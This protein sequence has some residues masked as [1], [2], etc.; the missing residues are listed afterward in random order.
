MY[1]VL[2]GFVLSPPPPPTTMDNSNKDDN[3]EQQQQQIW[4]F[5]VHQVT[6]VMVENEEDSTTLASTPISWLESCQAVDPDTNV[7]TF[8]VSAWT[9]ASPEALCEAVQRRLDDAAKDLAPSQIEHNNGDDGGTSGDFRLKDTTTDE[10]TPKLFGM[11]VEVWASA[12]APLPM[13][14]SGGYDA[15]LQYNAHDQVSNQSTLQRWGLL[16]QRQLLSSQSDRLSQLQHLVRQAIVDVQQ[17]M[18]T[19]RPHVCMGKDVFLFREIASRQPFRFDLR[20]DTPSSTTATTSSATTPNNE[21]VDWVQTNL[22][23]NDSET[24]VAT[25]VHETLQCDDFKFDVSV[26]Y[27]LPGAGY[28]NW[29]ADGAHQRQKSQPA[30]HPQED[31]D[32]TTRLPPPPQAYAPPYALC[33]FIPLMDLNETVG[34]TQFWPG[35][36]R[37]R[38]LAGFGQV[39]TLVGATVST[40]LATA[41]D[42]LWYDY[43]LLHRGMPNTSADTLRDV[44]QIVFYQPWYVERAN[45]GTESIIP[46]AET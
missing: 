1:C 41:G 32:K 46:G 37:Y 8:V 38:D 25:L 31:D 44:L 10:I 15:L 22:L 9:A 14:P 42:A 26:V 18:A 43:R 11:Q 3:D 13:P 7:L 5:L 19:H 28:Q 34:Y 29:H 20:L 35:S 6:D 36:H 27:S 40:C 12:P 30:S 39:A 2:L 16:K 17:L 45:Y 24:G 21:I 23:D 33:L 4:N